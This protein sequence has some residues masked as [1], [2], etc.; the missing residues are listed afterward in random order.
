MNLRLT[1]EMFRHSIPFPLEFLR[2]HFA[3]FGIPPSAGGAGISSGALNP[4]N[5]IDLR[6]RDEVMIDKQN[7]EYK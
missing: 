6:N 4:I 2:T 3:S 5:E 7:T 1:R